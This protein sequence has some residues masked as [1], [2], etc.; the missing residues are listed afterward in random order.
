MTKRWLITG[1]NSGLGLALTRAALAA[2]DEVVAAVRRPDTLTEF[3]ADHPGVTV[4]ALDVRDPAAAEAAV[5]TAGP[6]DI[7]V[8]NAGFALIGAIEETPEDDLREALEVMYLGPMRLTRLVLP[9]M[10]ARQGGTIIQISSMGGFAAFAGVGAYCAAKAA[11]ELASEALAAE[12]ASHGIRVLVVEPGEFRTRFAEPSAIRTAPELP[13]YADTVGLLR[14]TLPAS[15]ETQMGDPAKLAEAVLTTLASPTPPLRLPL[16]PDAVTAIRAK[17]ATVSADLNAT[18]D[19][20][21]T[22]SYV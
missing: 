14:K 16:G 20:S 12:V 7:L 21:E 15:H 1:A 18:A 13:A 10:R 6:I 3:A 17:L 4:V 5:A 8:N 11:L 19:L 2:G 9:G 22:T